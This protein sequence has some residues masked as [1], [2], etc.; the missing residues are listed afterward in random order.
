[1]DILLFFVDTLTE[2]DADYK[3][4]QNTNGT[5]FVYQ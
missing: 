1:M 3:T 5:K 4:A 2:C